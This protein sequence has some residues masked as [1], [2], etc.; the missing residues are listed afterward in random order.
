MS[1]AVIRFAGRFLFARP[2]SPSSSTSVPSPVHVVGANVTFN[3]LISDCPH[4]T[5]VTAPFGSYQHGR[6]KRPDARIVVQQGTP[7]PLE[8]AIWDLAGLH[9]ELPDVSGGVSWGPC[10]CLPD[11]TQLAN[12][13]FE[14]KLLGAPGPTS[15][16]SM[17]VTL[18][19][20]TVDPQRGDSIK[21]LT[22]VDPT[23]ATV[24]S[25]QTAKYVD[26]SV[27]VG[28]VL[29][30]LTTCPADGATSAI[31]LD[32]ASIGPGSPLII[33]NLCAQQGSQTSSAEPEFAAY[34]DLLTSPPSLTT[35]MIPVLPRV[36]ILGVGAECYLSSQAMY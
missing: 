28:N 9:L 22:L 4:R 35:R 18:N 25:S 5:F 33:S 11:V 12:S 2:S 24:Q 34:Y 1:T 32:A 7:D 36:K 17:S 21:W 13:T 6:G 31:A 26:V 30:I 8:F 19:G 15:P 27:S 10:N 14:T 23:N 20:G 29:W 16:V 3:P